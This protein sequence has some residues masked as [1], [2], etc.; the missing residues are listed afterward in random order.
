MFTY[1]QVDSWPHVAN[2][3]IHKIPFKFT[4]PSMTLYEQFFN[5]FSVATETKIWA[6]LFETLCAVRSPQSPFATYGT[7]LLGGE[8]ISVGLAI[9]V[10][11]IQ[12]GAH[13]LLARF[14]F[15]EPTPSTSGSGWDRGRVQGASQPLTVPLTP[16][17]LTSFLTS[18]IAYL[19]AQIFF[20][21]MTYSFKYLISCKS[22]LSEF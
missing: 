15:L 22:R 13:C 7:V 11:A 5:S 4:W 6:E 21:S 14:P 17:P 18:D 12:K 9:S 16:Q 3:H 1:R 20:S 2:T 10:S 19:R 8:D